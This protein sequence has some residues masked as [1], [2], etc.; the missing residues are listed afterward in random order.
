MSL[1]TTTFPRFFHHFGRKSIHLTFFLSLF[2]ALFLFP[3]GSLHAQ[4]YSFS[5]PELRMQVFI[6]PDGSALIVYDIALANTPAGESIRIIDIGTPHDN[7]DLSNMSATIDGAPLSDIRRSEFID[8]GVEIHLGDRPISAGDTAT[9][10]FELTMP[11]MVFQD[12]TDSDYASFRISPAWF[13][14]SMI[15]GTSD[16]WVVVHTLPGI[17]ASELL[18]QNVA[19]T[20]KMNF[21]DHAVGSWRWESGSVTEEN[22]VGISFPKRGVANVI[23]QS[24]IDLA[25]EWLDDNQGARIGLGI[26]TLALLTIAFFRFTGGTGIT[27]YVMLGIALTALLVLNP[28]WQLV[29]LPVMMVIVGSVELFLSRRKP[30]Y[31]P[32]IVQ[33]EGG[34]I[35]RGL[36]APEAAVI[37]GLPLNKILTLILFGLLEKGVVKQ[38]STDPLEVEVSPEFQ[39]LQLEDNDRRSFRLKV[40]QEMGIVLRQYEHSFIKLLEQ[41]AGMPVYKIDFSRPMKSL[42]KHT[43]SRMKGFDLSETQEY[44]QAI[45]DKALKRA[46]KIG[47]I[48][49]RER[50]LDKNLQWLLLSDNYSSVFTAPH[51]NYRP[52]WI[53]PF[54]SSDRIGMPTGSRPRSPGQTSFTDV[55]ASFAGWTEKTMG[56]LTDSIAPGALTVKGPSGLVNLAGIDRVTG[57]AFTALAESSSSGGG[58]SGG[59]GC[60]CACAG[61]ACA[62]ACAGGGR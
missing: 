50:Y 4:Q 25:V 24:P 6:L 61:C 21:E 35:K 41:K 14:E 36:T 18:Y 29:A 34:G 49:E 5:V 3:S 32:A 38:L 59:G 22:L 20:D 57:D 19:F 56:S 2:L 40:A 37:L 60:A 52:V 42:I 15:S 16:I 12:T 62:C 53:R 11:D 7:Y 10:H 48:P 33:V 8:T 1:S 31:F 28:I 26:L 13:D 44:Y 23:E 58:G 17:D 47:D 30:R 46:G 51:Y 39:S 45:I 27:L 9:L 54:H 55:A 43:A